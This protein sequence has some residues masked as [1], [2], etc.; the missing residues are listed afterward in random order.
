MK[1]RVPKRDVEELQSR[2]HTAETLLAAQTAPDTDGDIKPYRQQNRTLDL[3]QPK[4]SL[5]SILQVCL[6]S[7][8]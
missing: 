7:D 2:M 6:L 4:E 8:R 5:V 3:S 1:Q